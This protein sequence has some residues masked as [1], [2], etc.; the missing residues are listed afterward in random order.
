MKRRYRLRD[1]ERFRQVRQTGKSYPHG[2]LVLCL[3]PNEEKVS[4]CGFTASRRIGNAVA[5]NRA[6]RRMSEVVR[7]LWDLIEPGYDM[8]WIARPGIDQTDFLVLQAACLHLLRRA[9]VL[10]ASSEAVPGV[11][12]KTTAQVAAGQRQSANTQGVVHK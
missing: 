2:L 9:R 11:E 6:R 4:R 5:R 12:T 7:L 1:K 10:R 8:V 3:L